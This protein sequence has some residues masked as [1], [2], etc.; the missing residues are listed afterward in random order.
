MSYDIAA[1]HGW[2][3]GRKV[4]VQDERAINRFRELS[5]RIQNDNGPLEA[6]IIKTHHTACR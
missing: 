2:F 5:R 4:S 6:A 1:T 3:G